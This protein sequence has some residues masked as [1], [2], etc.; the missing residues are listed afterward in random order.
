MHLSKN[1]LHLDS[2]YVRFIKAAAKNSAF[3][4]HCEIG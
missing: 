2:E 4:R 3:L 1:K